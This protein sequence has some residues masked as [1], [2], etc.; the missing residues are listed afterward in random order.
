MTATSGDPSPAAPAARGVRGLAGREAAEAEPL[1]RWWHP[2]A[3]AHDVGT[4]PYGTVLLGRGIVI[5]RDAGGSPRCFRD[6]CLHRGTALSLGSVDG[7]RLVCPYHGW[8]YEPDGRCSRIPQLPPDQAIPAGARAVAFRCEERH[9]LIWACLAPPEVEPA[10]A[11]PD[12]PEYRDPAFRH[13]PIPAYTWRTSAP[14]MLENFTDIGHLA[15][16]HDGLL[17]SK[18]DTVVPPHSVQAR[19]TELHYSLEHAGA[20]RGRHQRH[21]G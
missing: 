7:G 20:E 1:L 5:W 4:E 21:S 11:I 14:R 10:A 8:A 16:L 12:F 15:W 19:G 6:L 9:G 13:V 3:W 18:D 2:V 17:G